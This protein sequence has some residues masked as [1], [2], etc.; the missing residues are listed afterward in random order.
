MVL[1]H[2]TATRNNS[3]L[4]NHTI[5]CV[6]AL[7]VFF[8]SSWASEAGRELVSCLF[9]FGGKGRGAVTLSSIYIG[10]ARQAGSLFLAYLGSAG[11]GGGQL[12]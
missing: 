8:S 7:H 6:N 2:C 9:G 5:C 4:H 11:R 10:Q 3:D 1:T 12:H